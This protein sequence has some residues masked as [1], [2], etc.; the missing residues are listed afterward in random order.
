MRLNRNGFF[1]RAFYSLRG[2]GMVYCTTQTRW[3]VDGTQRPAFTVCHTRH[4]ESQE[5]HHAMGFDADLDLHDRRLS[6]LI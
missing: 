1:R 4:L 3:F 6:P 5:L 2:M